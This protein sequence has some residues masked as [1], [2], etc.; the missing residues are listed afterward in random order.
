MCNPNI[1]INNCSSVKPIV[2]YYENL[3]Q[4]FRDLYVGKRS[5]NINKANKSNA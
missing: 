4:V 5:G 1:N 3:Q 2:N